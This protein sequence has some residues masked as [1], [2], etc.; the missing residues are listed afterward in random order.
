MIIAFALV[1]WLLF[2]RRSGME[3]VKA[4]DADR[5]YYGFWYVLEVSLPVVKLGLADVWRP[6]PERHYA[7]RY[8]FVLKVIGWIVVGSGLLAV[9]GLIN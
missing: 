1:N 9:T 2:F 5:K 4:E 6:K 3:P 8:L 7:Y